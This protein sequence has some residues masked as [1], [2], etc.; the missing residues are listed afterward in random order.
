MNAFE[1]YQAAFDAAQGDNRAATA[2]Y[3]QDYA[4]NAMDVSISKEVAQQIADCRAAFLA[5]VEAS[6]QEMQNWS[7]HNVQS[8]LEEIE[9]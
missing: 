8:D 5:E 7:Y 4:S 6:N 1:I 3:V 9:V 2:E